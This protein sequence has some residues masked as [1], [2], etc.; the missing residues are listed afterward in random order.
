MSGLAAM[1]GQQTSVDSVNFKYDANKRKQQQ[2]AQENP[3]PFFGKIQLFRFNNE[4]QQSDSYGTY[5]LCVRPMLPAYQ[6][7]VYQN[8]SQPIINIQI[9]SSIKWILRDKV[10]VYLTEAPNGTMW[11]I[12]FAD[13][14]SA[15]RCTI[16]IGSIL[17]N[18]N[19]KQMALFE[20]VQGTGQVVDVGDTVS[21]S[22]IGFLGDKLPMTGKKFDSN[23]N[24]TFTVGSEKT[25]KGWSAGATGMHVGGTRVLIIP[26]EFAYGSN[27]VGNIIPPNST[28][29]FL[30]TITSAKSNKPVVSQPQEQ[31]QATVQQ[32]P[33]Q[34]QQEQTQNQ[35][36][37]TTPSQQQQQQLETSN[38]SPQQS[39]FQERMKRMGAVQM[40]PQQMIP[41]SDQSSSDFSAEASKRYESESDSQMRITTSTVPQQ[42]SISTTQTSSNIA[43]QPQ[44]TQQQPQ[45]IVKVVQ[46]PTVDEAQVLARMDQLNQLLT[47]KFDS[48][49]STVNTEMSSAVLCDEIQQLA[50]DLERKE[51]QI[52]DQQ[53]L[54]EE[55]KTTKTGARLKIE[56]E[57]TQQEL[58]QLKTVL[59]G[60][61]DFRRENEDLRTEL[62]RLREENLAQLETNI[63]ELREELANEKQT[64]AA[65]AATRAKELFFGFMGSAVEELKQ[66]FSGK[67]QVPA[68][69]VTA[70]VS[71][72][73]QKCQ[74]R[75]FRQIDEEGLL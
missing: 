70:I 3:F 51:R 74:E 44:I 9:T 42:S 68:E 18:A 47:T 35:P 30:M 12:Q 73:F 64:S 54:I 33:P 6:L 27:S 49:M 52:K 29:T 23:D 7:V 71:D 58:E 69:D 36:Q 43:Q 57:N 40:M 45:Q 60:G 63:G 26:P 59:R 4:T 41:P 25:I 20:V 31:Q 1:F 21:A 39:A 10:Y 48:L 13:P 46:A 75:T 65:A 66:R 62:R 61:R 34:T 67:D 28:L 32:Q 17:E 19:G 2:Q 15:S 37:T 5:I 72:V 56:L 11:T 22:Y 38:A 53:H 55:L 24:Y 50:A 8:Q 16:T 14:E